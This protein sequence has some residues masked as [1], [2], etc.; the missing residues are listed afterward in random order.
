M[1]SYQERE[2]QR[3]NGT[4]ETMLDFPLSSIS[5]PEREY[6]DDLPEE[7]YLNDKDFLVFRMTHNNQTYEEANEKNKKSILELEGSLKDWREVYRVREANK[8]DQA[9]ISMA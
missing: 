6:L 8:S 2:L 4:N 5:P 3:V 7:H 1:Q 9:N